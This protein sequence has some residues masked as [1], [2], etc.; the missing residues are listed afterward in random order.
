MA[1]VKLERE[2]SDPCF[3]FQ[4]WASCTPDMRCRRRKNHKDRHRHTVQ[5]PMTHTNRPLSIRFDLR[6][7]PPRGSAGL[8][9]GPLPLKSNSTFFLFRSFI[10]ASLALQ[11]ILSHWWGGE[12]SRSVSVLGVDFAILW[13]YAHRRTVATSAPHG[14]AWKVPKRKRRV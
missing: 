11:D 1:C 5:R 12:C 6:G 7:R 14:N 4:D 9:G 2:V 3:V 8:G 10:M 13:S